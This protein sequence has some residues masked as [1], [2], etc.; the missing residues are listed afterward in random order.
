MLTF[1]KGVGR[2]P[3]A[4][5]AMA[6]YLAE[7]TVPDEAMELADYY[8]RGIE[9]V[10]AEG[11]AAIPRSDMAPAVAAA[12]GLDMGRTAKVSEVANL[13]QGLRAD[14]E[15]IEGRQ[16]Y[17]VGAGQDRVSYLDMTFSAPKSVSVAMALAP[18][19]AERHII[20]GAHRDAWMAAMAHL[21]TIIAHARKGAAGSKGSV[22]GKLGWVSFDHYTARPTI[23]VPHTEDDGTRTTLIQSVRNPAVPADMQLHTH[24]TVPNVVFADAVRAK[25]LVRLFRG[26]GEDRT[27]VLCD[28]LWCDPGSTNNAPRLGENEGI[29]LGFESPFAHSLCV[30]PL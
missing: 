11:T 22:P 10:E 1:S 8:V 19:E 24:V 18:T 28:V 29:D 12:L 23:Q 27:D 14:G 3:S 26:Q 2:A 6:E 15:A 7:S 16:S 9:R 25:H 13:L 17:K 5:R 30:D 21:E 20:V 4:A